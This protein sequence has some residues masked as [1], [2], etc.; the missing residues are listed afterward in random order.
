MKPNKENIIT[1]ILIELEKCTTRAECLAVNGSKWQVSERTFGRYWKEAN[2][3]HLEKQIAIQKQIEEESRAKSKELLDL[4]L[5]SK[6]DILWKLQE[7]I[8]DAEKDSDK[9]N[10]CKLFCEIEGFKAPIKSDMNIIAP[11]PIFGFN[12][13]VDE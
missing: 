7:I 2:S 5:F 6:S 13:L 10:A 12:P 1:D 4:A 3:R 11:T 8:T 9:I